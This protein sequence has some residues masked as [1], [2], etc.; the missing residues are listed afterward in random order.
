[1]ASLPLPPPPSPVLKK[2]SVASL[3]SA[4]PKKHAAPPLQPSRHI[5]DVIVV[6][7]QPGGLLAAALLAKRGLQILQIDPL[8]HAPF[9]EQ[10]GTL[11]PLGPR[12]VPSLRVLPR[13]EQALYEL[14]IN[15]DLSRLQEGE[16]HA[17]Q[18]LLPRE[19][20][21]HSLDD[22]VLRSEI[23]RVF[24]KSVEA[25]GELLAQATRAAEET[26]GFFSAALPFPPQGF[27]DRFRLRN[28]VKALC[29]PALPESDVV[30]LDDLPSQRPAPDIVAL[31]HAL[32]ALCG[33]LTAFNEHNDLGEAR[34]LSHL[35]RGAHG[36]AGG[37]LGLSAQLGQRML[38]LGCDVL[39]APGRVTPVS[40][41][42]FSF[43]R[44]EGLA[45]AGASTPLHAKY[46]LCA[47]DAQDLALLLPEKKAAKLQ[48]FAAPLQTLCV[49]LTLN[50]LVRAQGLPLGLAERAVFFSSSQ[51]DLGPIL[52]E[53]SR[54]QPDGATRD[55][56]RVLT[57]TV[58]LAR[59]A[60]DSPD[61][62]KAY[63]AR[64]EQAIVDEVCPFLDRH[65]LARSIP[66][67]AA[68]PGQ[69]AVCVG[70]SRPNKSFLGLT[71][72]PQKTCFKNLYLANR[73]VLPGLGLEGELIAGIRL[74]ELIQ[75]KLHKHNPLK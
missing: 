13:V 26:Q 31:R 15:L 20:F 69:Q 75:R 9:Y 59:D 70:F 60:L 21:D 27:W 34:A 49:G 18:I 30:A 74:A 29:P 36:F 58:R 8:G 44:I 47:M 45:L 35:L 54:V 64:L 52:V 28:F 42:S 41:F 11:F 68:G 71:G 4:L 40:E 56:Q 2:T 55:E 48:R 67:F 57:I 22:E 73:Q 37:E 5:Y 6:G 53:T 12:L 51:S 1:M 16:G 19:R 65:I 39:G 66:M 50:L 72:L 32:Q 17:L 3:S 23:A 61:K 25:V 33:F 62:I 46:F 7:M 63:A 38:D 10:G 14:G 43:S 24:P